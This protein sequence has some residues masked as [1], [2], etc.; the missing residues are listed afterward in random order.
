VQQIEWFL[1]SRAQQHD[2]KIEFLV[3]SIR[4]RPSLSYVGADRIQR[5]PDQ[6]WIGDNDA[7]DAY[8]RYRAEW[9][10]RVIT[11]PDGLVWE[12]DERERSEEYEARQREVMG[13]EY[14]EIIGHQRIVDALEKVIADPSISGVDEFAFRVVGDWPQGF[15]YLFGSYQYGGIPSPDTDPGVVHAVSAAL[16]G[17]GYRIGPAEP[18]VG[19]IGV[20]FYQGRF[21]AFFYPVKQA[22]PFI[23]RDVDLSDFSTLVAREHGVTLM[24]FA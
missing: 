15:R 11:Y 4:G 10:R 6:Q 8:Q 17:F 16:G 7:F 21:G 24:A 5:E 13:D 1:Q 18:G 19:A 14:D 2:G 20:Y 9:W 22:E 3:A 12:I 23:Y